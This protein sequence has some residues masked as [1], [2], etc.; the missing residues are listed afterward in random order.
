MKAMKNMY[1]LF[2]YIM[3]HLCVWLTKVTSLTYD[4]LYFCR[5]Q[6][7][8]FISPIICH[9]QI[10]SLYCFG[11]YLAGFFPPLRMTVKQSFKCLITLRWCDYR[12]SYYCCFL[13][14]FFFLNIR[15]DVLKIML[16]L[17]ILIQWVTSVF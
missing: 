12:K 15:I 13:C 7:H 1:L 11:Y 17:R 16:Y 2:Y 8:L 14:V 5:L 6:V 10:T 3:T 4:L 9:I